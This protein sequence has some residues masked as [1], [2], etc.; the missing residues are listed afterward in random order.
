LELY[1]AMDEMHENK[2]GAAGRVAH[3][4]AAAVTDRKS[5]TCSIASP[6]DLIT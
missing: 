1:K 4:R 5:V 6:Q 3:A 2:Q